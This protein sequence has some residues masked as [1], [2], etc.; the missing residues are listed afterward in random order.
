MK[1]SIYVRLLAEGEKKLTL[2]LGQG[3]HVGLPCRGFKRPIKSIDEW[4]L[5]TCEARD[6]LENCES[7]VDNSLL[8]QKGARCCNGSQDPAC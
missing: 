5:R 6:L 4:T 8:V 7:R 1:C 2:P 3:F